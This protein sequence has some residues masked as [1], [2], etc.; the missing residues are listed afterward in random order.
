M[1][2]ESRFA[3]DTTVRQIDERR[4]Q[5]EVAKGWDILGVPNGGYIMA[6]AARALAGALPHPHPLS[7]SGYYLERTEPGPAELHCELLRAGKTVSSACLRF[8]Q[9]GRERA[10]F[11]ASF[12]DLASQAGPSFV[13][14][15]PPQLPA[16]AQ[17]ERHVMPVNISER[18]DLLTP[19][20]QASWLEGKT[21]EHAEHTGW[22]ALSEGGEPDPLSLLL[23]ADGFPPA[24]F[25][26]FG[27]TGWVPTLDLAVQ[28]RA[29]PAPGHILGRFR[30]R[31]LTDGQME[32]DGELWD[33]RGRLVAL[34][35]Q[36]AR[37]RLPE[38]Q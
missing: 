1:A 14:E 2:T 18:L 32:E 21:G 27:P 10:R 31:Y 9:G 29:L 24:V 3:R 6:I 23:F 8:M 30:T 5:A 35:R 17:C 19:P 25:A 37:F 28:V 38:R 11:L 15:T 36:L 4:W 34:S 7:V 12:A 26:R 22:I 16:P 20:G 33:S 13:D